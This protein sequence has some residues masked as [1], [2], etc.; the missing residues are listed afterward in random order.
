[1]SGEKVSDDVI[2]FF[3][4]NREKWLE[5]SNQSLKYNQFFRIYISLII[6]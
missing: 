2:F 5:S 4:Y 1:M 6:H 3:E